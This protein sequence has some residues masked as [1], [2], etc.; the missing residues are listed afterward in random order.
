MDDKLKEKLTRHRLFAG[1]EKVI[2]K[3]EF[4]QETK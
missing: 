2:S 1:L 4:I 3:A